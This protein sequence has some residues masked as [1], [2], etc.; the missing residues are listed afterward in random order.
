MTVDPDAL[1]EKELDYED[2]ILIL[3]TL[4]GEILIRQFNQSRM[5]FEACS[6]L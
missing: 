2:L 1:A 5:E 4:A 3:L 6:N